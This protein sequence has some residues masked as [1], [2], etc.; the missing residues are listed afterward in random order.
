MDG[1]DTDQACLN[2][3]YF[4]SLRS[5]AL[6]SVPNA[7]AAYGVDAE[8]A[9]SVRDMSLQQIEDLAL[10]RMMIFK[11]AIPTNQFIRMIGLPDA[12]SRHVVARMSVKQH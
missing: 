3:M 10:S 2:R 7:C 1:R 6:I 5:A 8:F 4:M 12:K 9:A 11:P